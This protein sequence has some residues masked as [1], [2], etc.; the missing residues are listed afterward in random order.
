MSL[1]SRV[2]CICTHPA[3]ISILAIGE[4]WKAPVATLNALLRSGIS[5][6]E[7][8]C[9]LFR[10]FHCRNPISFDQSFVYHLEGFH[11]RRHAV[12]GDV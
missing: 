5:E 4:I 2:Y 6:S 10:I 9:L 11:V 12:W 3:I 7:M 8:V 1:A